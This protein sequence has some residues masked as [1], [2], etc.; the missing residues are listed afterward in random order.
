MDTVPETMS[1]L[2]PDMLN[3]VG[4]LHDVSG[5]RRE[6]EK[7]FVRATIGASA[8]YWVEQE[9]PDEQWDPQSMS[10]SRKGGGDGDAPGADLMELRGAHGVS[11]LIGDFGRLCD[12]AG[13][14]G[15]RTDDQAGAAV[16]AF[17]RENLV[18]FVERKKRVKSTW[19]AT[20]T[21]NLP[22]SGRDQFE[23]VNAAVQAVW[24]AIDA[25]LTGFAALMRA[26]RDAGNTVEKQLEALQTLAASRG[27]VDALAQPLAEAVG[28]GAADAG[29]L[30]G[31]MRLERSK[32]MGLAAQFST[33]KG[34]WKVGN[35]HVTDLT[36]G[37]V[38]VEMGRV[39]I[40][41]VETFN[42]E[43]DDWKRWK[44]AR[45]EKARRERPREGA[46]Q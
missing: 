39:N 44:E 42:K 31:D 30:S 3:L 14:V 18:K 46:Q 10:R 19:A 24:D 40:V 16:V 5:P 12:E 26:A 6:L 37:K 8:G 35:G 21:G 20:A 25:A 45:E 36:S 38:K 23:K 4:E 1:A 29:E 2:V 22:E 32:F 34:V 41:S 33:L 13:R 17:A 7:E 28:S 9:F 27:T 11:I 43:F 15:A